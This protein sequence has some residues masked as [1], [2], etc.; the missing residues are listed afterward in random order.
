[1]KY[2]KATNYALHTM[3]YLTMV[4]KG[5]SV[6][7]EP[8]AKVQNLSPTY[9][10]KILTKL[11]KDG[12]VESTPG[13]KG[14]YRIRKKRESITF[15]DVIE[16]VE[17]QHALFYCSMEHDAFTRNHDCLIE[18]VMSNAEEKMK[19]ELSQQYIVDIAEKIDTTHHANVFLGNEG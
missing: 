12:L 1:M 17:G 19:N 7:V 2:S 5:Q 16:A 3:V 6:G 15:L 18:E 8:L 10:S 4:P 14:G 9:L 13:V 11:T